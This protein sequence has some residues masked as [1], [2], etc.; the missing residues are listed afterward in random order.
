MNY[1]LPSD[2]EIGESLGPMEESGAS[3][4]QGFIMFS[5]VKAGKEVVSDKKDELNEFDLNER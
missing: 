5:K 1:E 3:A 2:T 4:K